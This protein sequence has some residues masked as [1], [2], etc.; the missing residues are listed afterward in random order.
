QREK[1]S[2]RAGAREFGSS[3]MTFWRHLKAAH[4][5][6]DA[7]KA[8]I[9]A[10]MN[11]LKWQTLIGQFHPNKQVEAVTYFAKLRHKQ[12]SKR[13]KNKIITAYTTASNAQRIEFLKWLPTFKYEGA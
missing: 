8:L 11:K 5:T 7:R 9:E 4:V 6:K 2:C 1:Y 12:K 3:P 10:G 13:N